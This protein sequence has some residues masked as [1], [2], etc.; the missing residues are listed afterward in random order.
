MP[1]KDM[2]LDTYV[3]S[4]LA[5]SHVRAELKKYV[6]SYNKSNKQDPLTIVDLFTRDY[7]KL[8]AAITENG[9]VDPKIIENSFNKLFKNLST[10]FPTPGQSYKSG[11]IRTYAKE[12]YPQGAS[13]V[14]RITNMVYTLTHSGNYIYSPGLVCHDLPNIVIDLYDHLIEFKEL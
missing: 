3:S 4:N 2:L 11:I 8:Y 5:E 7:P 6:T 10:T 9:Q 12:A 14:H 1:S 13:F